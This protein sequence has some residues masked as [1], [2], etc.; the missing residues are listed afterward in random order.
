ML[1]KVVLCCLLGQ[2]WSVKLASNASRQRSGMKSMDHPGCTC[3]ANNA[4]WTPTSRTT[5]KCI[6][7]D[8]GAADGNTFA[9][10][11]ED[12]FGPVKNCPHGGDWEAFLV[13]ANPMFTRKLN[14]L[15]HNLAGKLHAFPQTA[16]FSCET[17][18][19][20]FIDADPTHNFWASSLTNLVTVGQ[21][22]VTVPTINVNKFIAENILPDDYVLLKVDIEGAEYDVIPCLADFEKA[23]LVDS[24][25]LE[26][27]W[28]FQGRT[29]EQNAT[30]LAAK[31]KLRAKNVA[32][33]LYFSQS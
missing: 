7:I 31:E 13:E 22:K 32:I 20:F 18:T 14:A 5:P 21:Q 29:A 11:L 3:E 16:A 8:L 12:D 24:L 19:S 25:Y 2:A 26:E 9:E 1:G 4:A 17:T 23:S 28:W 15:E 6:F 10:F 27:H 33:P 30:L